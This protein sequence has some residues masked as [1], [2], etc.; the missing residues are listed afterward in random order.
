M[1]ASGT[2]WAYGRLL[3]PVWQGIAWHYP[4][5]VIVECPPT[6]VLSTHPLSL[7]ATALQGLV[8]N[9]VIARNPTN[10]PTS[11]RAI[12]VAIFRRAQCAVPA[13]SF[14]KWSGVLLAVQEGGRRRWACSSSACG[15]KPQPHA[16][17]AQQYP[18]ELVL[19]CSPALPC[20]TEPAVARTY[21]RKW[22][23]DVGPGKAAASVPLHCCQLVA[24]HSMD[25]GNTEASLHISNASFLQWRP[26]RCQMCAI[27]WTG[28]TTSEPLVLLLDVQQP[29]SQQYL[30]DGHCHCWEQ[31]PAAAQPCYGVSLDCRA[32]MLHQADDCAVARSAGSGWAA[33]SRRSSPSPQPCSVFPTPCHACATPTGFTR[34]CVAVWG[35]CAWFG[36]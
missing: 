25:H 32:F 1:I 2:R 14:G 24:P 28:S 20:S 36:S 3:P 26:T 33:P 18:A 19:M 4:T 30:T 29:L 34:R 23:G 7:H 5:C 10:Q 6:A 21:L 9:Y 16:A 31:P 35:A 8:C 27:S 13:D 15:S 11:E 22:C 17:A 12:P